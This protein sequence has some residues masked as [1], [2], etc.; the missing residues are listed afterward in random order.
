[1]DN[2]VF[3]NRKV[4]IPVSDTVVEIQVYINKRDSIEH[5]FDEGL[6]YGI[7]AAI[8]CIAPWM[9]NYYPTISDK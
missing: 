7:R 1:M 2:W 8:E 5:A 9:N 3:I 4:N 6:Y